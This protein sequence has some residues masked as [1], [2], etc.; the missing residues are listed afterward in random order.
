MVSGVFVRNLYCQLHSVLAQLAG[1]V[2]ACR[3]NLRRSAAHT[4]QKIVWLSEAWV[5]VDCR[6]LRPYKRL[7]ISLLDRQWALSR[8][9]EFGWA[10]SKTTAASVDRGNG[11]LSSNLSLV[12]VSK[13][14]Q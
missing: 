13:G 14:K 12:L 2:H 11:R 8:R 4:G 1:T 9:S 6:R 7:R 5:L 3:V 10:D